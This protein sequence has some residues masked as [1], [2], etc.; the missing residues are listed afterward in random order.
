MQLV[1]FGNEDDFLRPVGL[2]PKAK[3]QMRQGG[4]SLPPLPLPV[5]PLRRSEKKR[6][7]S[8]A[9]LIGKV[10]WGSYK[11]FTWENGQSTRVYDWNMIPGDCQAILRQA[12]KYLKMDYKV[13]TTD[14]KSFNSTPAEIPVLYFSGGRSLN[15]S[16]EERKK[17]RHYSL[18][19]GMLWFDSVVGSPYFYKSSL[20]ELKSIFP[21]AAIKRLPDDHPIFHMIEDSNVVN[22]KTKESIK[23]VLDGI[24]IGSR[25]TAVVSPYGLGVGWDGAKPDLIS[26]ANYYDRDSSIK[27]GLNLVAYSVGYFRLGQSQSRAEVF[28][29]DD[30][31]ENLD[32]LVFAQIKT[33]GVWNTEP[34]APEKLFRFMNKNLN[35]KTNLKVQTIKLDQQDLSNFTFLY[36]SGVSDFQLSDKEL[37]ALKNYLLDG[38]YLFINNS[39]G[40]SEFQNY[41]RQT[42]HQLFPEHKLKSLPM[43]HPLYETGPFEIKQAQ[44]TLPVRAKYPQLHTPVLE[45]ITIDGDI[46]VIFSPFDLA[47]GW[48]GDDHPLSYS[49]LPGESLQIGAN[50]MTYFMTH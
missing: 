27:L 44:Y 43:S 48:Q 6:P 14:L 11:D 12:Y 17:L 20:S 41:A 34:G 29:S 46:R 42:L 1:S 4:E 36:L 10:I 50:I 38:G 25:V 19:G 28:R 3:P 5:T 8:P 13:E 35:I 31:E 30:L 2:P 39:L 26:K 45:A 23:P 18:S 7:P 22:V 33:N 9:T 24:Y 21:D 49:Y 32:P 40:L 15:F 37:R 47:A 16:E